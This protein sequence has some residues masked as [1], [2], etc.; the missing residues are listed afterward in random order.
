MKTLMYRYWRNSWS[1][2][3]SVDL[4]N[5]SITRKLR[6]MTTFSG[7]T[8]MSII[9]LPWSWNRFTMTYFR[10]QLSFSLAILEYIKT[11]DWNF[12]FIVDFV[13]N[14]TSVHSKSER[15][16]FATNFHQDDLENGFFRVHRHFS[17][18]SCSWIWL[19]LFPDQLKHPWAS[20]HLWR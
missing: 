7:S 13:L 19:Q 20:L 9:I 6:V 18:I 8:C 11:Q 2:P 4:H 15:V 16:Y 12:L 5:V 10:Y 1:R 3:L 17:S 14:V